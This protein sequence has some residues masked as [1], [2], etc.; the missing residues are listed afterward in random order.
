MLSSHSSKHLVPATAALLILLFAGKSRA[1]TL[2]TTAPYIVAQSDYGG[3]NGNFGGVQAGYPFTQTFTPAMGGTLYSLSGGFYAPQSGMQPYYIFQFRD[4]TAGGIPSSQVIA[5][6]NVP[7]TPLAAPAYAWIDLTADFSSFG[8][9][10]VAG[11]RYA[12][13]IDVP[14]QF[15]STTFNNFFW[16]LTGSGYA[17][18]DVYYIPPGGAVLLDSTEDFLFT[19]QAVPEPSPIL[20]VLLSAWPLSNHLRRRLESNHI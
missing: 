3:E 8:L 4:T 12:F 11:H 7:T 2:V 9:N 15:G 10:L 5:S 1:Q 13:S 18:G 14:G 16:G 19:I 17:G 20:L 6:V